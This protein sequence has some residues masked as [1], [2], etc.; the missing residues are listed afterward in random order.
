ME[1]DNTCDP[2]NCDNII[3]E[4]VLDNIPPHPKGSPIQ[5]TYR[6]DENATLVVNVKDVVSGKAI[7]ASFERPSGLSTQELAQARSDL[8]TVNVTA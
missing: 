4:A 8:Q 2:T 6:W 5:I 1:E 7:T 3:G